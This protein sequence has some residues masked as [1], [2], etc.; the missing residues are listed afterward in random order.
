[1]KSITSI[2]VIAVSIGAYFVYMKPLIVEIKIKSAQK[3]EYDNVLNKVKEIKEKRE[4]VFSDYNSIPS[5]DI[6]RLNKI[7]PSEVNSVAMLN[8]LGALVSASGL[9]VVEY[10]VSKP[11]SSNRENIVS[12]SDK[13]Y[14]TSSISL[15]VSGQYNQFINFLTSIESNLSLL[16]IVSL[17]IKQGAEKVGASPPMDYTLEANTYSLR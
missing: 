13:M 6:E 8:D 10:K 2:L 14:T 5:A 16:D 11:D 4:A 7:I 17:S 9:K 12:D 1:M 3:S 15:K